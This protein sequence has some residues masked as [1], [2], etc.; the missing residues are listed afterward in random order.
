LICYERDNYRREIEKAEKLKEFEKETDK[1]NKG[2]LKSNLELY[3]TQVVDL[4]QRVEELEE[5]NKRLK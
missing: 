3:K 4:E 1:M 5:E 2:Q